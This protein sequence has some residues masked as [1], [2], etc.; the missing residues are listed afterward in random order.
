MG[1][2]TDYT[3]SEELVRKAADRLAEVFGTRRTEMT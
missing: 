3:V 1:E 2:E